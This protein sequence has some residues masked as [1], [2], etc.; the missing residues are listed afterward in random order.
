MRRAQERVKPDISV[1]LVSKQPQPFGDA[2]AA[3]LLADYSS[4]VTFPWEKA[5]PDQ[6]RP[7]DAVRR[8]IEYVGADPTTPELVETP[9]RVLKFLDELRERADGDFEATAFEIDHQDLV[10]VRTIPLYSLCPH[11]LLPFFGTAHVGYIPAR[12]RVLGLSKLARAVAKESAGLRTQ[13]ALTAAV[14]DSIKQSAQ[15]EDVAV[16]TKAVHSCMIMRG[17]K[18]FGSETITSSMLGEF[19]AQ[20]ALRAEFLSLTVGGK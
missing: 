3:L 2:Y 15:T 13:E 20:P 9:R 14:A 18:A 10:V 12:G 5:D 4:W 16:V 8:L 7:E 19:R 1:V 17:V 6:G 11:H